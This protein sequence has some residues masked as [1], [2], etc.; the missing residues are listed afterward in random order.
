M[1]SSESLII[2]RELRVVINV[3]ILSLNRWPLTGPVSEWPTR[4][5]Q[6]AHDLHL[7]PREIRQAGDR[8]SLEDLGALPSQPTPLRSY[9]PCKS[10]QLQL[11]PGKET[12]AGC[13]WPV[14]PVQPTGT[15]AFEH[16]F[17]TPMILELFQSYT[18]PVL[19]ITWLQNSE[20]RTQRR[21]KRSPFQ[22]WW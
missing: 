8:G 4:C 1:K 5:S 19:L 13:P 3:S 2:P 14:T 22:D 20:K 16:G 15:W 12:D 18:V 21:N 10:N 6:T 11:R 17:F 9:T 7:S